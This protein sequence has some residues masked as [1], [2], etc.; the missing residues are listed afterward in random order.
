MLAKNT[1]LPRARTPAARFC[2]VHFAVVLVELD[3]GGLHTLKRIPQPLVQ[4]A[5]EHK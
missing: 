3:Y 2:E 1:S 5:L 4:I